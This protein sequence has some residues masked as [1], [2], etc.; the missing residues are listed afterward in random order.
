M[1]S[2]TSGREFLKALVLSLSERPWTRRDAVHA[3]HAIHAIHLLIIIVVVIVLIGILVGKRDLLGVHHRHWVVEVRSWERAELL[4]VGKGCAVDAVHSI[5][6]VEVWRHEIWHLHHSRI[7]HA[8]HGHEWHP[9]HRHRHHTRHHWEAH[10]LH[11]LH[12]V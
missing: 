5:H 2:W 11:V 7:H 1:R 12:H 4:L 6:T 3:I 8:G 10:V 9:W